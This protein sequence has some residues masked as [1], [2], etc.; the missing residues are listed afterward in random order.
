VTA[1]SLAGLRPAPPVDPRFDVQAF[2]RTPLLW[3]FAPIEG[4]FEVTGTL[5]EPRGGEGSER[6]HAGLDVHAVEGTPV[7]IVRDGVVDDPTA[8]GDF[9]TLNESVR[10]GPI[11]YV[12]LR[13]GRYPRDGV[14]D[15]S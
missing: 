10:I 7:R 5:G 9:A 11:T 14:F 8:A 1:R 3:P 13:V 6:F 4:P 15:D 12:H 2:D